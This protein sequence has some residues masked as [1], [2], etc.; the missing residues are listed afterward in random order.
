MVFSLHYEFAFSCYNTTSEF[1]VNL[2]FTLVQLKK[3]NSCLLSRIYTVI[4]SDFKLKQK[5]TELLLVKLFS[6]FTEVSP[7]SVSL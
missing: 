5:F 1:S 3:L 7:S 4:F 2:A 6:L